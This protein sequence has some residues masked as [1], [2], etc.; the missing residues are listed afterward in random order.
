MDVDLQSDAVAATKSTVVN[1]L[2]IRGPSYAR[3]TTPIYIRTSGVLALGPG[4]RVYQGGNYAYEYVRELMSFTGGTVLNLVQQDSYPV[5][6]GGLTVLNTANNA[7]YD[8]VLTNAGARPSDRDAVDKRVI[9]QVR[10]RTGRIINCVAADGS[11]RCSRNAGGWPSLAQNRRALTLPTNP[12]SVA[13]N[14]YTNLENWLNTLDQS[15]GGVLHAGSPAAPLTL[16][17]Q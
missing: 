12:N 17:V 10:N 2:F 9:T 15:V 8:R 5:W 11:T 6:N 13:A 1:N 3:D 7:V 4:S 16:Q 14:G